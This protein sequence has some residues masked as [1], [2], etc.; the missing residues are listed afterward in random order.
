MNRVGS[1]SSGFSGG[2]SFSGSSGFS[3]GGGFSG[4]SGGFSGG[5]FSGSGGFSGNTNSLGP[6]TN[7][8][9]SQMTG[10]G[11]GFTGGSGT[12]TGFGGFGSAG[13]ARGTAS[14]VT[15]GIQPSNLIGAYYANP[16][17]FGLPNVSRVTF[18]QPLYT[19]TTSVTQTTGLGALGGA[20]PG[21]VA[22]A[23]PSV[24]GAAPSYAVV[25]GFDRPP[26]TTAPRL[27]TDLEQILTRS[28]AL[29][30]NRAI[31]IDVVGGT[32]VLR[33]MVASDHDRRMAEG[34]VRMTPGVRDVRNELQTLE[35]LPPPERVP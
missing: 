21:G 10:T 19:T 1:G 4:S 18:G 22:G 2:S 6:S 32:V 24:A 9:P 26:V 30:P 3:G 27:Q 20:R 12:G 29:S 33:G 17:G 7:L 23:A 35:A 14:G 8:A 25:A 13:G 11:L 16:L 34:L 31:R 28:S 5:S 15:A